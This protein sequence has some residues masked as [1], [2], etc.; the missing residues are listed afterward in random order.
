ML[1]KA[2][3]NLKPQIIE[4]LQEL[5]KI[6]AIAPSSGGE[7]ELKKADY[8]WNLISGWGFDDLKRYDCDKRP[9]IVAK[10]EGE[11]KQTLWIVTHLDIVP[12]GNL[13]LWE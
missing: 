8:T 3:D 10:I 11:K 1:E 2:I 7:G 9:N 5:V 12:P 6:P 13:A 4:T